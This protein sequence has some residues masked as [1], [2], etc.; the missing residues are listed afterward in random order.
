MSGEGCQEWGVVAAVESRQGFTEDSIMRLLCM[1][2]WKGA[3]T[4]ET[5]ARRF[6]GAD[7]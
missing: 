2:S 4:G 5:L 6:A 3:D 1:G 7:C